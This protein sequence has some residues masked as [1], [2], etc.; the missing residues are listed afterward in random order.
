MEIIAAGLAIAPVQM[1]YY[2]LLVE[3]EMRIYPSHGFIVLG[4]GTP[5]RIE[6]TEEMRDWVLDL[7]GQIRAARAARAAVDAPIPSQPDA[8]GV[9]SLRIACRRGF[10]A[11]VSYVII[12]VFG[13]K[14]T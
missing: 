1:S 9:A 5:H 8:A 4:D 3:E 2:C 7:A 13:R 14:R 12:V 11:Y 10:E 6:N